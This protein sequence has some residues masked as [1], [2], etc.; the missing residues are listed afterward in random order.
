M[1]HRRLALAAVG[2]FVVDVAYGFVAWRVVMGD[3]MVG[4]PV[5]RPDADV[6]AMLPVVFLGALIGLFALAYIFAK[7]Y[8]GGPGWV[9]GIRFGAL[10]GVFVVAFIHPGVYATFAV[11]LDLALMAAGLSFVEMVLIGTVIGALY[12]PT[13][14]QVATPTATASF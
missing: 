10:L 9:E 14:R 6:N 12:R 4:N 1:N 7:G 5:F 2:A 11:D 8:E 3:R 13:V